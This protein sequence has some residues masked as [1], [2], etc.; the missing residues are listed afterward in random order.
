MDA[1]EREEFEKRL[2]REVVLR[3]RA[4]ERLV[5][6]RRRVR[7]LLQLLPVEPVGHRS[8]NHRVIVSAL[9]SAETERLQFEED[10]LAEWQAL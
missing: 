1:N 7:E 5:H 9:V 6:L 10:E 8:N 3:K 4:Q 2:D